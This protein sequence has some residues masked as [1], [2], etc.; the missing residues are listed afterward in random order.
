MENKRH[1]LD[2]WGGQ[3]SISSY[4]ISLGKEINQLISD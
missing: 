4:Q 3:L 2:I 1:V